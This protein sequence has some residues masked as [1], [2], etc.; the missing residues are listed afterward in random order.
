MTLQ[1]D[2]SGPRRVLVGALAGG[3][4]V[5]GLFGVGAPASF[6]Q[7]DEPT[8]TTEADEPTAEADAPKRPCT[9]DDCGN[10][11]ETA[12]KVNADQVLNT[13]YGEYSIGDGGGQV[14]KLIDDAMKL[15]AQGF[16][17]SNANA[18]ALKDALEYRPNQSPLVEALKETIAYQ[19]KLQAQAAMSAASG[20]VAGPVPQYTPPTGDL[21]VPVGPGGNAGITIP[22]G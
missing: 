1:I 4:L 15:R 7:P 14:S 22:I 9:G 17:P 8:T 20:P 12:P 21:T 3:A 11:E 2:S 16:R 6:A 19:R 13:I 18:V 5:A 10:T